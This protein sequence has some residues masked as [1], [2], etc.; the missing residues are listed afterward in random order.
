M[1]CPK[2]G[3]QN[4]DN[5]KFC[6]K[7]GSPLTS[8]PAG[9]QPSAAAPGEQSILKNKVFLVCLG[10]VLIVLAAG[11]FSLSADN[12][13]SGAVKKAVRSVETGNYNAF[14]SSFS[15]D[16]LEMFETIRQDPKVLFEEVKA[17]TEKKQG[18]KS[19]EITKETING[20]KAEF[21]S[22]LTYGDGSIDET[23]D[24]LVKEGGEWKIPF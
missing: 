1:N 4:A 13:P 9:S 15:K 14:R 10:V 23:C 19:L 20:E 21:C 7:C 22:K 6:I 18:V 24:D 11:G 16:A 8:V 12:T 5:A 3:N 2:C 17:E